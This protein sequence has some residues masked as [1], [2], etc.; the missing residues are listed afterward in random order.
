MDKYS[1]EDIKKVKRYPPQKDSTIQR[2]YYRKGSF[3]Q[4][5]LKLLKQKIFKESGFRGSIKE[6]QAKIYNIKSLD[7]TR[8]WM[9][10]LK[11]RFQLRTL[12]RNYES[13][14]Q[15]YEKKINPY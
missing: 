1:K 7:Q 3:P 9:I 12:I 10:I 11:K 4:K 2:N 6:K 15:E 8:H 13:K 5:C 14:T